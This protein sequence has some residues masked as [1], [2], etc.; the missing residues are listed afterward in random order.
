MATLVE[1]RGNTMKLRLYIPLTTVLLA[2]LWGG[3]GC[4]G[5]KVQLKHQVAVGA[6]VTNQTF[7]DSL[8]GE[9]RAD[10]LP[11]NRLTPLVNGDQIVPAMIGAIRSARR[12]VNLETYLWKSGR[13]SDEFIAALTDRA[14]AG[15]EVRVIADAVGSSKL[16]KRDEEK[17][18]AAGVRFVRY[19]KPRLHLL[20]RA[21]FRDHRKLMIVDGTVAFTG[22]A[23]VGD[24]W[25]GNA[26]TK[27]QW[28]DTHFKVEGPA[29]RQ[30]QGIFGANWLKAQGEMLF[31]EK[32]YPSL[33]PTGETVAQNFASGPQD[34]GE[35]GRLVYLSAIAAAKKRI[36]LEHAYFLPDDLALEALH[37]AL[38]RG[39]EIE[40][41]TPGEIDRK[42]VQKASR[43]FWPELIRAGM[44][45]YEY[46]PAM[47][48]CKILIVDDH[49]VSCGSVNF[50]PRS[51]KITDESNLN[52]LDA[53]FAGRLTADFERDK[54]QARLIRLEELKEA[55]WY[56]KL[57]QQMIS[58]FRPQL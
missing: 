35:F 11:G 13:M 34:G 56:Q 58:L 50:D 9:I 47:L 31:G 43:T 29:V 36:R 28:R 39:V 57:G 4:R 6:T 15:V 48:H 44:K 7:R 38:K 10:F 27:D 53:D 54:A 37:D 8:A 52:V 55:P 33:S 14:Q 2:T 21:N 24:A 23:C 32:F 3:P 51:L 49:F 19:N 45:I 22:G 40:L 17:M 30:I 12:T 20:N 16:E 42:L 5:P 18:L 1:T 26:E 41:L 25:Y 46:G